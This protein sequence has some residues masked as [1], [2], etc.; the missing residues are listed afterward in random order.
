MEDLLSRRPHPV[1]FH[2]PYFNKVI[3]HD[4]YESRQLYQDIRLIF[5]VP[6]SNSQ[7]THERDNRNLLVSF[8][9]FVFGAL[10]LRRSQET[11]LNPDKSCEHLQT[12]RKF[13]FFSSEQGS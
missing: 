9:S 11:A 7:R 8:N 2:I 13:I 6:K 3:T 12:V 10:Q 1:F 4:E 5:N